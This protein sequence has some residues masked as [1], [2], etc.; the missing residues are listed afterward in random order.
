MAS[1]IAACASSTSTE[2]PRRVTKA[3]PARNVHEDQNVSAGDVV[4]DG[5]SDASPT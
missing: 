1:I 3:L 5:K 2:P 4:D